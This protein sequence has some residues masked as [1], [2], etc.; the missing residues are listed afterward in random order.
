MATL[1]SP[2]FLAFPFRIG[3][4]G[5][6]TADRS[7]HVRQQIEQVLFTNP[8]ERVFRAEFG[9]GVQA[10]VFEPNDS[11]LAAVTKKRLL[12]TLAEALAGEV[13][14]R[15]LTVDVV[16]E[17]EKVFI[18]ITYTLATLGHTERQQILLGTAGTPAGGAH[19]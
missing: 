15:T 18:V 2:R 4:S 11:A 17:E 1:P 9:A 3:T 14:P 10:L 7:Q 19:G 12:S 5:A 16:S 13:D 6:A 8:G